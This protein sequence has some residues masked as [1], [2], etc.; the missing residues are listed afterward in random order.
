MQ[1]RQAAG[2]FKAGPKKAAGTAPESVGALPPLL[3]ALPP[4]NGSA[5]NATPNATANAEKRS[6]RNVVHPTDAPA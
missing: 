2:A 1:V 6:G 3:G 4:L 5:T